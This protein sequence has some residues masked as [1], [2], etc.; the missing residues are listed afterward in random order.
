MRRRS[1]VKESWTRWGSGTARG[2]G[3]GTGAGMP[4]GWAPRY[5]VAVGGAGCAVE[6]RERRP[7]AI[8]TNVEFLAAV[9]LTFASGT[10]Q[11][12]ASNVHLWAHCRLVCPFEQK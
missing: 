12:D 4:S 8:E 5:E 10:G 7:D 11:H 3:V 2:P 9:E 6:L 1:V